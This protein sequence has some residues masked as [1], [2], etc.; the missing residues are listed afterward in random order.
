[1]VCYNGF[2]EGPVMPKQHLMPVFMAAVLVGSTSSI[3]AQTSGINFDITDFVKVARPQC[4]NLYP[5][6]VTVKDC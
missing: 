6:V 3:S 5:R 1:M 4:L 2:S